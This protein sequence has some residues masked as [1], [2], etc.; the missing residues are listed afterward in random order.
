MSIFERD[1]LTG[2]HAK[3]STWH[4]I[5]TKWTH[6][7]DELKVFLPYINSI[8]SVIQ[9]TYNCSQERTL[10]LVVSMDNISS[11][12]QNCLLTLLIL[13]NTYW[14]LVALIILSGTYL[15]ANPSE[16][17]VFGPT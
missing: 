2:M 11:I 5:C 8:H 7:E 17:Y 4:N 1:F 14:L 10:F 15:M 13:T 16:Y 3:S 6:A 9:N 12:R